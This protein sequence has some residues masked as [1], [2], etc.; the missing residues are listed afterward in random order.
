MK[1]YFV[2]ASGTGVGKT[3]YTRILCRQLRAQG[4]SVRALKPIISG[5]DEADPE[6]DTR[7]LLEAQGEAFTL[8]TVERASPFRFQAPLSPDMAA[9][10]EGRTVDY[11]E[12]LDFCRDAMAGPED[13]LLIEGI[14][15]VMVPLTETKTVLDWMAA[16]DIPAVLV[17]GSYLGSLSH[18]LTAARAV[19][20]VGVPLA[21]VI[22]SESEENPVP[23]GE[24]ADTLG[25]FLG[26]TPIEV[27]PR[28]ANMNSPPA[29][30]E[31]IIR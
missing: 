14:G 28:L 18:T 15:G 9:S 3:L 17:T 24:T 11:D 25:R 29:F 10:R 13:V 31:R 20:G 19:K 7:L 21:A 27:L 2:T 26:R 16:L 23:V 30:A 4:K 8:E 12:L 5:W 22:V 6:M 1:A